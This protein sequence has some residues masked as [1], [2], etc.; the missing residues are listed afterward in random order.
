MLVKL[1]W[2]EDGKAEH[3]YIEGESIDDVKQQCAAELSKRDLKVPAWA[4][5]VRSK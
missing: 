2:M 5:P 1:C 3:I 4:E